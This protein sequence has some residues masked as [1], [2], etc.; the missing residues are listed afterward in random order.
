MGL[1]MDEIDHRDAAP[2]PVLSR[3]TA[4]ELNNL[5][6]IISG[7][8]ALLQNIWEGSH[9]ADNYFTMLRSSIERATEV[10]TEL[11]I[12]AGASPQRSMLS[13]VM[14]GPPRPGRHADSR[15]HIL[16]TDDDALTLGLF[17]SFLT[18]AGF[19]V[20]SARSGFECL[21]CFRADPKSFDLVLLDLSMPLMDGVEVFSR[22]RQVDPRVPVSLTT[23]YVAKEQLD[24]LFVA[25][26]SGYLRKPCSGPEL[27]A[28]VQSILGKPAAAPA[29]MTPQAAAA[30]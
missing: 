1:I 10:T 28:H 12:K 25:G 23:G 26:L 8:T 21:D 3:A 14:T 5:L 16:V 29:S 22:L 24:E 18:E 9:N 4:S 11:A 7:T 15:D 13:K 19:A 20:T 17:N 27:V 6:Q 2:A 30:V